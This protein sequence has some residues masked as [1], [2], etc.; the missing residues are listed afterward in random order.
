MRAS[1]TETPIVGNI[2]F[3]K[4]GFVE[5]ERDIIGLDD[6][7]LKCLG[8]LISAVSGGAVK[9]ESEAQ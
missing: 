4:E 2:V 5:G 7:D 8:A 3:C 1:V 6:D 9:W